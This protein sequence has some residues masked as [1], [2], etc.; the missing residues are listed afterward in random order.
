MLEDKINS[1]NI[2]KL[3]KLFFPDK[4][5]SDV[6][7]I[8]SGNVNETYRVFLADSLIIKSFIVQR[9]NSKVLKDLD[10]V[11]YNY[12]KLESYFNLWNTT[13][14]S[15]LIAERWEFASLYKLKINDEFLA[16]YG[17]SNWRA[18]KNID[19]SI[20]YSL[21]S[22]IVN[23]REIGI[24]LAKFHMIYKDFKLDE[25]RPV[26]KH[27]HD[28][29]YYLDEFDLSY[30]KTLK[31]N[32]LSKSNNKIS[33]ILDFIANTRHLTDS[34]P[35]ASIRKM[36]TTQIVHTDPKLDNFMFDIDTN[37]VISLIDL[38]TVQPGLIINDIA[39]CMRSCCNPEGED[40]LLNDVD[41]NLDIFN[42]I[43]DGY[44]SIAKPILKKV[45]LENLYIYLRIISFELGVRFFTDYLNH[46]IYFHTEY[47]NHNLDRAEV[48]FTI[49]EII[50]K[51]NR[52][53][54][55]I[56]QN[57]SLKYEI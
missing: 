31:F 34:L 41:F 33:K 46:N 7:K 35:N 11:I 38:D 26:I 49:S 5:I 13:S 30:Q 56:L 57:L 29:C 19:N 18:I 9:L 44:C 8:T 50:Y 2:F 23:K 52:H 25:I 15:I 36:L 37:K 39:D 28:T 24:G 42:E 27:F 40:A 54:K 10:S 17:G 53:I 4:K 16:N 6:V 45:D 22:Q 55:H 3:S 1:D 51:K 47:E 12:L 20:N 32:E 48:Q 14:N 43:L 21:S